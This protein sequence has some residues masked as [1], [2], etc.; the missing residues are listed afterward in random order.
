MNTYLKRHPVATFL[1]INFAWTWSFWFAAMPFQTQDIL[2]AAIVTI[3]GFGPALAAVVTLGLKNGTLS[4]F[5]KKRAAFLSLVTMLIFGLFFLKYQLVELPFSLP[6]LICA[7]FASLVG[8]WVFS[9]VFSKLPEIRSRMASMLPRH[10]PLGWTLFALLFYPLMILLSWGLAALFGLDVE[11]PAFW[12]QPFLQVLPSLL[13]T[14]CMTFMAQGGNEEPGWRGFM[15]PTLQKRFSPLLAA[16]IVSFFWSLW[17]MPLFL[18]G[19]YQADLVSGMLGG[20]I[21]RILLSIFLAWFAN[22][23]G[24]NLFLIIF[25]HTSFNNMA[26]F[27]PTSDIILTLLWLVVVLVVV[28]RDKMWRKNPLIGNFMEENHAA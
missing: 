28:I 21:F 3:G 25:L 20:G 26:N 19:F 18:N 13:L 24:G 17:H 27:L 7:G 1:L 16:I 22:R 15:Q 23:S 11:L 2:L 12:G 9:S 5:S 4:D 10:L 6:L 14:F 8:G